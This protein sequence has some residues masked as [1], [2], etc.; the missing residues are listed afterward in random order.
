LIDECVHVCLGSISVDAVLADQP[1]D[2]F[3]VSRTLE[4]PAPELT[5]GAVDREIM[6]R[7]E[8][9]GENL[10]LDLPPF[11]SRGTQF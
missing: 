5:A 1:V 2:Q 4:Q 6:R 9:E 7:V 10:A 3:P 8:V 11:D